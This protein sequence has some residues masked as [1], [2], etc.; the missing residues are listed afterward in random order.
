MPLWLTHMLAMVALGYHPYWWIPRDVAS[1]KEDG[2][3]QSRTDTFHR[4]RWWWRFGFVAL[5]SLLASLPAWGQWAQFALSAVGLGLLGGGW[6]F[7]AFTPGLNVA[8]HLD[9]IKEYHVSWA[10]GASWPDRKLWAW[11]WRRVRLPNETVLP[12]FPRPDVA[13][14]AGRMLHL[15]LWVVLGATASI[16]LAARILLLR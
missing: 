15:A 7:F 4:Q 13:K 1:F 12:D 3:N 6:F 2:A 14:E 10:V 16:Y 9:Y 11:A 5:V 8:R